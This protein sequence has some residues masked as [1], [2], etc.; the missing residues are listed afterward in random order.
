MVAWHRI[1]EKP[2]SE[3]MMVSS[4]GL[5][6]IITTV[7]LWLG[8]CN[9]SFIP[10]THLISISK[11]DLLEWWNL[12]LNHRD[13]KPH[14]LFQIT[15]AIWNSTQAISV[16]S[17]RSWLAQD[18]ACLVLKSKLHRTVAIRV[19]SHEIYGVSNHRQLNWMWNNLHMLI[20]KIS[21][22]S[23]LAPC[24]GNPALTG[25]FPSESVFWRLHDPCRG[26][27]W[28]TKNEWL[29]WHRKVWYVMTHPCLD[30]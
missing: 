22:I 28:T 26:L 23:I 8:G 1:G 27:S 11:M 3:P 15:V 16:Q 5:N 21:R 7:E 2:F 19:I 18:I 10:S 14:P 9:Y 24:E 25:G 20:A 30:V 17:D 29:R 12:P 4:L 6:G 13:S